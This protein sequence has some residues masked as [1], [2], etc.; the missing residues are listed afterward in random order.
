QAAAA[1]NNRPAEEAV[2]AN[3]GEAAILDGA[4]TNANP[5]E[6]AEPEVIPPAAEGDAGAG[7]GKAFKAPGFT[8][9]DL[10]PRFP[11]RAFGP[12]P[13]LDQNLIQ[14][15]ATFVLTGRLL[16]IFSHLMIVAGLIYLGARYFNNYWTAI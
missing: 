11:S 12:N 8:V 13:V 4:E 7:P 14:G 1:A 9:L 10:F 15:K 2:A 3:S 5:P 16:T 6:T